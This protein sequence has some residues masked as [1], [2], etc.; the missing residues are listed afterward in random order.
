M[1]SGGSLVRVF[2]DHNVAVSDPFS[3]FGEFAPQIRNSVAEVNLVPAQITVG[4]STLFNRGID[5]QFTGGVV[6][7]VS[8]FTFNGSA[9][10]QIVGVNPVFGGA[11]FVVNPVLGQSVFATGTGAASPNRGSHIR[12][13]NQMSRVSQLSPDYTPIDDFAGFSNYSGTGVSVSFGFGALPA[14]QLDLV[15]L[16]QT[17]ITTVSNPILV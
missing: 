16:P 1:A 10:D 11:G 7:T 12:V 6:P 14:P 9:N 5:P 3:P 2:A 8:A 4:A 13:F 15:R 17:T